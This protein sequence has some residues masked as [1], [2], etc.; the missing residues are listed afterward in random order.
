VKDARGN[1]VARKLDEIAVG[2]EP[3]CVAVHPNDLVAYVTNGIS[4]T[5]SVVDLALRTVV[6]EVTVGGG[7]KWT[8]SQIFHR[9]DPAAAAQNG[10][11]MDPGVT[12]LPV[13]AGPPP[14]PLAN[15][16]FSF[17]CNDLTFK[18]LEAV[19]TFDVSNAIEIRDNA[20]A[21]K[22]FGVNG[23]NPPSLLSVN[24]DAPY[25][26]R[27]EAQT[28]AEVFPLHGL[29]ASGSGFPPTTTIQTQ[30]TDPAR[31]PAHVPEV[32]RRHHS[33]LPVQGR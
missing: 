12:R 18:Y 7:A 19:G 8:K 1:D 29:G 10:P 6:R 33:P 30:L 24:Y 15:E 26:H 5:V 11:P 16:F 28:L 20:A 21:S 17:T 23:F 27:G 22:A 31:G 14:G 2:Q 4:G 13:T 25:L 32:D 9:G 3:R